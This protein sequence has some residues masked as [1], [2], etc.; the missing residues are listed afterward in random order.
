MPN[1]PSK[2]SDWGERFRI[3]FTEEFI[4]NRKNLSSESIKSFISETLSTQRTEVL[5]V[6]CK[7]CKDKIQLRDETSKV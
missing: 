3:R 4:G 2:I 1:Q 5:E 6:C 7:D